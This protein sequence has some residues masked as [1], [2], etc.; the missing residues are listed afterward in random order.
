MGRKLLIEELEEG[1]IAADEDEGIEACCDKNGEYVGKEVGAR[2]TGKIV[3]CRW[4]LRCT[5]AI[6]SSS[7]RCLNYKRGPQKPSSSSATFAFI[8]V[9]GAS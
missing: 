3:K 7:V 6:E 8:A 4:S 5:A 1:G 2:T 9:S